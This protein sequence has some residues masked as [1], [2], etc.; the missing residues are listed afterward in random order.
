MQATLTSVLDRHA[1]PVKL[2]ARSKRW[3][4]PELRHARS[5]WASARKQWQ[6]RACTRAT[7]KAARA[8]YYRQIRNAK[9][10]CWESFLGGTQDSLDDPNRCWQA[11]RYTKP[12]GNATT[13]ALHG[14]DPGASPATSLSEKEAL[15]RK[16]A[17]PDAPWSHTPKERPGGLAH[18]LITPERVQQALFSQ[19]TKKAPGEDRLNFKAYRLLWALDSPRIIALA[20]QCFRLGFHPKTWKTAKGIL[21][22]K[23]GKSDYSQ[24]KAWRVISLLSCLGK[25]IEKLA[26]GLIADWCEAQGIL[27]PGQMGSRRG[28][29]AIDAV[30][31]LVQ[32]VHQ[33]WAE[34]RLTGAAFI[35]VMGAFDHVDPYKLAEAMEA[36]GIDNDLIRWTLSF[37]TGRQ[38]GLIIDSQK[39][40]V[41]P[42]ASGLPQGSPVSPIL[43]LLYVLGVFQAIEHR[44]P[45]TKIISYVDDLGL[46]AQGSSVDE[47]CRQLEVAAEAAVDW[48]H[49]NSVEFDPKKTEATLFTRRTGRELKDQIRRARV[50]IAGASVA[51]RLETTK[52]LGVLLDPKLT[53]RDHHRDRLQK[54]Q[55]TEKRIRALCKAQGL[56]PGLVWRIQKATAQAVA[57]Y[58]A[59]LWWQGQKD[60]LEDVQAL[61]NSQARAVT[62]MLRTTPLGPLIREAA[63]EPAEALL[64]TKQRR[65]A[66]RLLGLPPGHPTAEVLPISLR[67]GDAHAQP[68][69]QPLG[70]RAWATPTRRGPWTLGLGL[71]RRVRESMATD[72]SR[73]FERTLEYT[74]KPIPLD[75]KVADP[76]TAM[77]QAT[78]PLEA[79][80]GTSLYSDGSRLDDKRIGAAAVYKPPTGPWK[81][82][83]APLGAG[84]EVFDAELVGVVEALEWAL[85]DNLPGPI[86]VLIDAQAAISRL[87]HARPGPGQALALKAHSLAGQLQ[88]TGRR[89]FISWVPGHKGVPGNEEAD[90]A[91][92]KAAGRPP[93]GKYSGISLAHARRTCTEASR[94]S[95]ADWLTKQLA[96]RA[97]RPGHQAYSPPKGWKLDPVAAGTPKRL[98]QRYY[99][100][101][102]GH[103]PIGTFL[104]RIKARDSPACLGCSRGNETVKHLFIDCRQW[105]RQRETLLE[106]L[107]EAGVEKPQA[108]ETCPEAR[109]LG[110]PKAT[111]ALLAFI[112]AI[113]EQED[114]RQAEEQAYRADNWGIEALEEDDREGDG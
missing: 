77:Q 14:T 15:I 40:D 17:F 106:A 98:A 101:K 34:K 111:K 51:F 35:D 68:G 36:A 4:R 49:A 41:H 113:R 80:G 6:A 42:I 88:A 67:E 1:K 86:R 93:T 32:T 54:G 55:S 23:P 27:H 109:L 24:V 46:I 74:N 103:A 7:F 20:R 53:F 102:T 63:L 96:K 99:Q 82:R 92:K 71:A 52:W 87:Q 73:G 21:L 114:T 43:F 31:Y 9:R 112:A 91:A 16:S 62:G 18:T 25:V 104:H 8:D 26:A 29:G 65:Y 12:P 81:S 19:S 44:V 22:K 105:R 100:F 75:F 56:P 69:E 59:E 13:P 28:R 83:L 90:K 66:V 108:S 94:A 97:R 2:C 84:F 39:A 64:D 50:S 11:L 58:G 72:P 110:E 37:L 78:D 79:L 85:A 60:R 38:V 48:G 61:I 33:G 76:E 30:A 47:V 107:A 89:V 95:R 5:L 10:T 70:D 3:W 45:G 57:L